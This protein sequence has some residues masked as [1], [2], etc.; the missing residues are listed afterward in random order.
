MS[1]GLFPP[2]NSYVMLAEVGFRGPIAEVALFGGAAANL[3]LG[4]LLLVGWRL[5][6]I[7]MAMLALLAVYS[8]AGLLL[9]P[10]YW[11]NPFAPI[12]KNLPIAGALIAMIAM[13][14]PSGAARRP[15]IEGRG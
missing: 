6:R 13:E 8:F 3:V 9:P 12:L 11:L 15:S 4:G 7:G 1:L 10:E 14:R 2:A 5:A